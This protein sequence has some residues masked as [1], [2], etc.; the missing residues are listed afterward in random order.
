[1]KYVF[2]NPMYLCHCPIALVVNLHS[3]YRALYKIFLTVVYSWSDRMALQKEEATK[4]NCSLFCLYWFQYSHF[5]L[6]SLF[7]VARSF[8]TSLCLSHQI[9]NVL[10][11]E[12]RY[13]LALERTTKCKLLKAELVDCWQWYQETSMFTYIRVTAVYLTL[14]L[15]AKALQQIPH[16]LINN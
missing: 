2:L 9:K 7:V 15:K 3:L 16:R 5:L 4:P 14:C 13:T 6:Y 8:R 1:M 10:F 12:M 11:G